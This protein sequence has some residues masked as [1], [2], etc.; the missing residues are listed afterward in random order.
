[1]SCSNSSSLGGIVVG[2]SR[3]AS[4][5]MLLPPKL[6]CKVMQEDDPAPYFPHEVCSCGGS[7][8][9]LEGSMKRLERRIDQLVRMLEAQQK[10]N[11]PGS[12]AGIDADKAF[13]SDLGRDIPCVD[14]APVSQRV[15][16]DNSEVSE[17]SPHMEVD[18]DE[19]S[20]VMHHGTGSDSPS[21]P[22]HDEAKRRISA[23]LSE[24][25]AMK[26]DDN[27][28]WLQKAVM[29][30]YF[31]AAMSI[32]V[33]ANAIVYGVQINAEAEYNSREQAFDYFE[34]SCTAI[35]IVE[36]ALRVFCIGPRRM[37]HGAEKFMTVVDVGLVLMSLLDALIKVILTSSGM[38]SSAALVRLV[39]VLR[40]G[41]LLRPL[42]TVAMLGELRVITA[43]IASSVRPLFWLICIMFFLTYMFSLLLTQ[44]AALYLNTSDSGN[45]EAHAE[46]KNAYGSVLRTMYSLFL[47]ATGG[48]DWGERAALIAH[49][50]Y[51]YA[52]MI[53][54]YIF[55]NQ[56]SVLNIVTGIFVDGA[57]EL[58]K[59]DR[60]L[61]IEKQRISRDENREHLVALLEQVDKDGNGVISKKEF[62]ASLDN[63]AV[64]DFMDALR[65][66]P[67]N[68]AEVFLLMDSDGNGVVQLM[69]FIQGMEKIQGEARSLDIH[70]LL[71]HTRKIIDMLYRMQGIESSI[72]NIRTRKPP[73]RGKTTDRW[74]A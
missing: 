60:S 7:F 15:P 67:N 19:K 20:E 11:P 71:L 44:G 28:S 47:A 72:M 25:Y 45:L 42:R 46:V 9:V 39:K 65:I 34:W 5:D 63:G 6:P 12:V 2:S 26:P 58:G 61:M 21:N 66:D 56:F 68:A 29:S 14:G 48:E 43:M 8:V 73:K 53:P 16:D 10:L 38:A 1:M 52:V 74:R 51:F 24:Y 55:I 31:D 4:V 40:I 18:C 36:L 30:A 41:R 49:A 59:K 50:G 54:V 17:C 3:Q 69:E 70:M 27:R 32:V 37:C 64:H 62:F 13:Q 35:F 33:L 22:V 23:R 57:I